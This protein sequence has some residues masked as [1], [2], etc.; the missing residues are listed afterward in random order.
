M[1]KKISNIAERELI[2]KEFGIS[3]KF[4]KLHSPS[5]I[6]DGSEECTLSII[7]MDNPAFISY[8]IWGLLPKNYVDEWSDFQKI[9]NTL[10]ISKEYLS[11]TR[12]FSEAYNQ[13]R[14]IIIVTGFFIYHLHN[15]SFYP[16][17]VYLSSKK[18]FYLGGI[19]N[20]LEDGFITC[21]IV[22]TKAKGI[23]KDIQNLNDTMPLLIAK[24][25]KKAWLDPDSEISEIDLLLNNPVDLDF[26]AHPIAKEFFK[27]DISYDSMLSPVYYKDIPIP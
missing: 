5:P 16:Y 2:E 1:Y 12:M 18:P 10:N 17:Y 24:E 9:F 14:C 4:P 8:G 21:S 20:T 13:R 19:Y 15:G 25:S 27:N 22:T 11:K 3:Y 26:C 7:T 6:L 23:I